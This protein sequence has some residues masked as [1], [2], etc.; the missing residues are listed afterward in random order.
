MSGE[1]DIC[2]EW[3]CVESRH[4]NGMKA[5]EL[6][7][8]MNYNKCREFIERNYNW[9]SLW[10]L[11]AKTEDVLNPK[12]TKCG[13]VTTQFRYGTKEPAERLEIFNQRVGEHIREVL[14]MLLWGKFHQV[15]IG[16]QLHTIADGFYTLYNRLPLPLDKIQIYYFGEDKKGTRFMRVTEHPDNTV[17]IL[18]DC[19][20]ELVNDNNKQKGQTND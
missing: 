12:T 9:L 1:C 8:G 5:D 13:I 3:G 17:T 7:D 2:G 19:R 15:E 14:F 11:N 6:L 4:D 18:S 10:F 20:I 16:Y